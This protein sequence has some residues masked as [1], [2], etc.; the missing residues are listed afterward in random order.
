[1]T[2]LL[3][4]QQYLRQSTPPGARAR[5]RAH[6]ARTALTALR[7][8]ADALGRSAAKQARSSLCAGGADAQPARARHRLRSLIEPATR[9]LR[10][11]S[12]ALVWRAQL[13]LARAAPF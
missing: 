11:I 9:R 10:V 13:Q 4:P 3:D 1:L 8:V 6:T 7:E 12:A 5:R 2:P